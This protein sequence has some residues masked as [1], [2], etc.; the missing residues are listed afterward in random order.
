MRKRNNWLPAIII[1]MI[2]VYL[3][4]ALVNEHNESFRIMS[5]AKQITIAM[6]IMVFVLFIQLFIHKHNS[7]K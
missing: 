1:M 7:Q 6:I 4:D 2:I 5:L 3:A